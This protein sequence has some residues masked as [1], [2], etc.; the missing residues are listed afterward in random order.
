VDGELHLG[1]F[2]WE[3]GKDGVRMADSS[4]A[5][6]GD[7][8]GPIMSRDS[9]SIVQVAVQSWI[10]TEETTQC[11]AEESSGLFTA[12]LVAPSYDW[13]REAMLALGSAAP[14]S[15]RPSKPHCLSESRS[16]G[17]QGNKPFVAWTISSTCD[18][19]VHCIFDAD[20]R[21]NKGSARRLRSPISIDPRGAYT[22]KLMSTDKLDS[23][24]VDTVCWQ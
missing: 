12:M 10:S 1:G 13:I 16:V 6:Y 24:I 23:I 7:S 3:R 8:G 15:E 22:E 14:L 19:E 21:T 4:M 11:Y 20:Y 18:V 5:C 17:Q 2:Q 9:R